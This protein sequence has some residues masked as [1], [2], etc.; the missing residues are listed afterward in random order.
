MRERGGEE[1]ETGREREEDR[2]TEMGGEGTQTVWV[3]IK[4][5]DM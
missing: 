4:E 3:I 1:G 2:A 5:Q